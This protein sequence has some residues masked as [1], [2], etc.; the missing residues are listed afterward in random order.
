MSHG[1]ASRA[2][3]LIH[4]PLDFVGSFSNR[5]SYGIAFGATANKVMF[6]F[7]E[8]YQPLQIPQW[9]QGKGCLVPAG[10]VAMTSLTL[11]ERVAGVPW[12]RGIKVMS[13]QR[14]SLPVTS[15]RKMP[16][17]PGL[18]ACLWGFLPGRFRAPLDIEQRLKK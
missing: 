10:N 16:C 14:S 3:S 6:L 18:K 7:S 4:R 11:R 8:G 1:L 15:P 12:D 17:P 13:S 5:W 9:A 2:V